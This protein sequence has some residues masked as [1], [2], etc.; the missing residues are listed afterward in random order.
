MGLASRCSG[1][2]TL[3]PL[4]KAKL[5]LGGKWAMLGQSSSVQ[6][7]LGWVRDKR[8]LVQITKTQSGTTL[9]MSP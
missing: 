5:G 4:G 3:L 2:S 6:S 1:D 9:E 7:K 8:L